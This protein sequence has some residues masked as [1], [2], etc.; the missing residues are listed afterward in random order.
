[1]ITISQPLSE[2]AEGI[3]DVIK[4]SW[5]ATYIDEQ[6][7]ITKQD[8]DAIYVNEPEKQIRAIRNRALNPKNDDISL[9]AKEDDVVIGIIRFKIHIESIELRTL[10]VLP[11]YVGRGVGTKLWK[12]SLNLLP[13]HKPITVELASYTKAKDFYEKIGFVDIGERYSNEESQMLHSGTLMPLMKMI[14]QRD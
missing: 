5:Y 6:I 13:V 7:G 8:I 2:D 11:G 12:E 14:Y 1:M 9:V 3:H 10:Y 4:K